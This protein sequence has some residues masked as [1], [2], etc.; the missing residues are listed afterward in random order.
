MR[1]LI[2]NE[3]AGHR[4]KVSACCKSSSR[5]H[6]LSASWPEAPVS[7]WTLI[8][9]Q[10]ILF[11]YGTITH[12]WVTSCVLCRSFHQHNHLLV[13]PISVFHGATRELLWW[14][15][16][17]FLHKAVA[18]LLEIAKRKT[19]WPFLCSKEVIKG[20]CFCHRLLLCFP[21]SSLWRVKSFQFTSW[22]VQVGFFFSVSFHTDIH[23]KS[24]VV[25]SLDTFSAFPL[26]YKELRGPAKPVCNN[27]KPLIIMQLISNE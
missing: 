14:R 12:H 24:W 15:K 13:P 7:A 25:L 16:D 10:S 19:H 4:G 1:G 21:Q 5:R 26:A 3:A 2:L 18:S 6:C 9:K 17:H 23:G 8:P 27:A 11:F 22:G 20:S